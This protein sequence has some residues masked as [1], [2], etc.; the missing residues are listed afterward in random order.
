MVIASLCTHLHHKAF[1][2]KGVILK[3][4]T[5]TIKLNKLFLRSKVYEHDKTAYK[6]MFEA[7]F[8]FK[9]LI[10]PE[11]IDHQQNFK[12]LKSAP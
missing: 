12:Y 1:D 9:E 8:K 7:K 4:L 2:R 3:Q 11:C 6:G 10:L 5:M